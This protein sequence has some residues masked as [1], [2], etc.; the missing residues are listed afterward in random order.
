MSLVDKA[1]KEAQKNGKKLNAE[2]IKGLRAVQAMH[3]MCK[4]SK[5]SVYKLYT[6]R[7]EK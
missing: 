2:A 1:K 5:G 4:R 7:Q 3:D 6:S